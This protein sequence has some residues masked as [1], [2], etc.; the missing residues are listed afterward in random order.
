MKISAPRLASQL[1]LATIEEFLDGD[2]EDV[3]LQD[4]DATNCLVTSLNMMGV[5][6]EKGIFTAAQLERIGARDLA[7]R[8]CDFSA[9]HLASGAIN[10]AE[11]NDCRMTG[12]DFN[13]TALH[14]VTFRDCKLDMANFRFADLR[15]VRFVDC[16]F[17]ESDFLNATLHDVQFESCT[18]EKV[19]FDQ[20][21]C[22]QVDLR[23]SQLVELSGWSSLKGAVIDTAQLM[24]IAPYLAQTIGVIV[25]E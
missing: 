5:R 20:A 12:V 2:L 4:V 23:T 16:L 11:F 8:H 6:V 22:K 13:K 7:V 19:V 24:A 10:R 18:L 21:K 15:R 14:D 25:K 17:V 3:L 9:A 1:E